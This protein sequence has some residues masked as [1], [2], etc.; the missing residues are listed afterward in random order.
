MSI[1]IL[2]ADDHQL[3]REG[4]KSLIEKQPDMEVVGDVSNGREAIDL[5]HKLQPDVIVMDIHMPEL[6]GIEATQQIIRDTPKIKILCLSM[7]SNRRLVADMLKAGAT[8]YLLK[9]S[10]SSELVDAIRNIS[11]G[12]T[13]LCHKVARVFVER[14]MNRQSQNGQEPMLSERESEILSLLAEGASTK[15][16]ALK[17]K[18]SSKTVDACRRQIMDKLKVQSIA[19]LVKYAIREGLTTIDL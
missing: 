16:I 7:Y 8:G 3:M 1:K 17:I 19:E 5:A 10:A 11:Q 13:Y 9:E 2:L 4:L 15:E 6:N 18:M 14:F 12:E